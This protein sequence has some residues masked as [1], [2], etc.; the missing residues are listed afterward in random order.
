MDKVAELL[1]VGRRDGVRAARPVDG[2]APGSM[3]PPVN[4]YC[5]AQQNRGTVFV[6]A[7]GYALQ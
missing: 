2:G 6:T 7:D 1:H 5:Y 4:G 3:T